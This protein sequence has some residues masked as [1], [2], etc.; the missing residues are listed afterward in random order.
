MHNNKWPY[1]RRSQTQ[2]DKRAVRETPAKLHFKH[3][4]TPQ[5]GKT[6]IKSRKS[7]SK[8]LEG[9]TC[10]NHSSTGQHFNTNG[11][12]KWRYAAPERGT[13]RQQISYE[14]KLDFSAVEE[15]ATRTQTTPENIEVTHRAATHRAQNY[16][17][18]TNCQD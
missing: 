6:K 8:L 14:I 18:R 3:R 17:S 2:T 9:L 4:R 15:I 13:N 5:R 11:D 1:A 16:N 12:W 7:E 10:S